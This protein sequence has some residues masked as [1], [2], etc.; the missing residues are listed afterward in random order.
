MDDMRCL[1]KGEFAVVLN[2][3]ESVVQD[4]DDAMLGSSQAHC[5]QF[6]V[7]RIG[8][9]TTEDT[10]K[11]GLAYGCTL[12]SISTEF[13]FP[14]WMLRMEA[15]TEVT[16]RSLSRE[17]GGKRLFSE[18]FPGEGV[19]DDHES[20]WEDSDR[21]RPKENLERNVSCTGGVDRPREYVDT[22]S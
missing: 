4:S 18:L 11:S 7:A 14:V 19:D 2:L 12:F 5:W 8:G 16:N 1:G 13:P 3:E 22:L 6:D 17:E 20:T 15:S 10:T 21:R 9:S